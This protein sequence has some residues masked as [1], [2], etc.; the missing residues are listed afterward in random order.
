MAWLLSH[1]GE[2]TGFKCGSN[3]VTRY[4]RRERKCT[5]SK[6]ARTWVCAAFQYKESNTNC[7]LNVTYTTAYIANPSAVRNLITAEWHRVL[8]C[9]TLLLS[10]TQTKK[11]KG[12]W[13]G[14]RLNVFFNTILML[15]IEGT[16]QWKHKKGEHWESVI[17][18]FASRQFKALKIHL[19]LWLW[20]MLVELMHL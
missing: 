13:G 20:S 11:E 15:A 16:V 9:N 5:Q 7:S 6:H 17:S 2:N 19:R 3:L 18:R 10:V 8:H 1:V 4:W 12:K 14:V